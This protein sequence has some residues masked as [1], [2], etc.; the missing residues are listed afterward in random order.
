VLMPG[1][2]IRTHCVYDNSGNDNPVLGG[3]AT[4]DEMCVNFVLYYPKSDQL[5]ECGNL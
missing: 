5:D 3:T 1:D 2:E 4:A